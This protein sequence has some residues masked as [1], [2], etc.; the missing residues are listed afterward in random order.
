MIKASTPFHDTGWTRKGDD[1]HN[2]SGCPHSFNY[3]IT[4]ATDELIGVKRAMVFS[5][6]DVGK[7][8]ASAFRRSDAPVFISECD[9]IYALQAC[10]EGLQAEAIENVVSEIDIIVSPAGNSNIISVEHMKKRKNNAVAS[11]MK[12]WKAR[13]STK[14]NLKWIVPC[15]PMDTGQTHQCLSPKAT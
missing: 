14:S 8:C 11:N 15:S 6:G 4:R 2:V 13:R 9:L 3:S 1:G 7:G 10:M 12:A 5:Y